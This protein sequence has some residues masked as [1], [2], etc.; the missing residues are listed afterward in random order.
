MG[1]VEAGGFPFFIFLLVSFT[2]VNISYAGGEGSITRAQCPDA[3]DVRCSKTHHRGNCVD[4]CNSCCRA[5][6][7]VPSGVVG[8]KDE[9]P[10]YRDRKTHDGK[11]KCP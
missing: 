4:T 6:L 2:I 7:C 3:C 5:C 9:C 11:P 8:H 1:K 10:C